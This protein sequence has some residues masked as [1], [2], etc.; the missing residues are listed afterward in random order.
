MALQQTL[1][2]QS[3][4]LSSSAYRGNKLTTITDL[5][6]G[7]EVGQVLQYGDR[8]WT[9]SEFIRA[10]GYKSE[11]EAIAAIWEFYQVWLRQ[12]VS[13]ILECDNITSISHYGKNIGSYWRLGQTW[14]TQRKCTQGKEFRN[15]ATE[16]EAIDYLTEAHLKGWD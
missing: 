4:G 8:Y 10:E 9:S 16:K 11:K 6:C 2:Q 12:P 13:F 14:I 1:T 15:F 7:R 3:F 5:S